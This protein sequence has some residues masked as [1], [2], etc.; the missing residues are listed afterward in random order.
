MENG[1]RTGPKQVENDESVQNQTSGTSSRRLKR[2][3]RSYLSL[4]SPSNIQKPAGMSGLGFQTSNCHPGR[5]EVLSVVWH[6][7]QT[8]DSR[9]MA[10]PRILPRRTCA[11]I[12]LLSARRSAEENTADG[13]MAVHVQKEKV[14]NILLVRRLDRPSDVFGVVWT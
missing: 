6:Y 2:W 14:R 3:I 1:L 7:G 10:S 11:H 4:R 8:S 12:H 5:L 13:C 9:G